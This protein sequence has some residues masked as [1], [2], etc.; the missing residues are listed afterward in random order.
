MALTLTEYKTPVVDENGCAYHARAVGWERYDGMWE[1]WV[2]FE[3]EDGVRVLRSARETSQPNLTDLEYWATG[4]TPVYLEGTLRRAMEPPRRLPAEAAE[5]AFDGPR[6][7]SAAQPAV[8]SVDAVLNP[9]AV[10]RKRPD[11]LAQEL[12]A[13]RGHHL[14]NIIRAYH[15]AD[16]TTTSLTA[17]SDRRLVELIVRQVSAMSR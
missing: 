17:L 5:P 9:F 15:L 11:M 10:F 12:Q 13:L 2:E 1:G 14:R 6:P 3:S 7:H 16:E 4:L 8:P